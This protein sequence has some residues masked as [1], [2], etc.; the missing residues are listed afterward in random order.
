MLAACDYELL[1]KRFKEGELQLDV[2]EN[3]YNDVMVDK[4]TF[5]KHLAVC[6]IANLIGDRVIKY[7]INAGYVNK[8]T[9]IHISG[10]P[11]VQILK[12]I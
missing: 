11:H 4:M 1:G 7:A 12:L 10:I 2:N 5:L 3:F 8:H 9:V 6:T